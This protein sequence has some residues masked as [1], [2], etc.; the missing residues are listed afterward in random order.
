MSQNIPFYLLALLREFFSSLG[1][2]PDLRFFFVFGSF[3][4]STV[5][6]IL[7][8]NSLEFRLVAAYIWALLSA[9]FYVILEM[10]ISGN[11][12]ETACFA[13]H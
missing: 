1:K 5:T 7:R 4:I 8:I 3:Q 10:N 6:K 2:I 12:R 11:S 9:I 13:M